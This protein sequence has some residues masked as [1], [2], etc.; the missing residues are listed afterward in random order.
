MLSYRDITLQNVLATVVQW[1]SRTVTI[2][3][4]LLQFFVLCCQS[5]TR[6]QIGV[7][8][9]PV[10]RSWNEMKVQWFKVHSK[11]KSR[12]SLTKGNWDETVAITALGSEELC[13]PPPVDHSGQSC[14]RQGICVI[15]E[16]ALGLF[17]R[18]F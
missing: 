11:A 15:W 6:L 14:W 12:L 3:E 1:G 18:A 13:K 9:R 17:F 2:V 7:D 4:Q 16:C 8:C 5:T 10:G